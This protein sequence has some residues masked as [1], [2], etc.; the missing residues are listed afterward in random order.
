M[1]EEKWKANE[2]AALKR[3]LDA[4]IDDYWLDAIGLTI[5]EAAF[6]MQTGGDPHAHEYRCA[7]DIDSEYNDYFDARGVI[8]AIHD[9]CAV[10]IND[11][12]AGQINLSGETYHPNQEMDV[13]KTYILKNSW[14]K[15]C[16]EGRYPHIAE[17]FKFKV[18]S[19]PVV[20][21][22]AVGIKIAQ[23][24]TPEAE[25]AKVEAGQ[26]GTPVTT[27][28]GAAAS[29]PGKMPNTTIGKFAIKAAWGI[30]CA[31][32]KRATAKQVIAKLQEW[33]PDEPVITE[34]IPHGVNWVTT[35]GKT[36]SFNIQTCAK[37]LETWNKSR[38]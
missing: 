16:L 30:E 1:S 23:G 37:A 36:N 24:V 31:T 12:C 21:V 32:G 11:I 14:L 18:S 7:H 9:K 26:A 8:D 28:V 2:A 4:P 6:W 33:E 5:Y 27:K 15:W 13:H 10:V 20:A 38:A 17:R 35:K 3:L 19:A 34:V 22:E 25:A 29:V